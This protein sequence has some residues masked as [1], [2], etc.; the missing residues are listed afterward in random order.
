MEI[1]LAVPHPVKHGAGHADQRLSDFPHSC[2]L[3][4]N[5]NMPT[6]ELTRGLAFRGIPMS[7]EGWKMDKI[8]CSHTVTLS[9]TEVNDPLLHDTV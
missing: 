8:C 6:Q 2:T 7:A 5:D 4:R 3:E 1:S 9:V